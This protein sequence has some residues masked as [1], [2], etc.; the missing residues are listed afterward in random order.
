MRKLPYRAPFFRWLFPLCPTLLLIILLVQKSSIPLFFSRYS[1]R[2]LVLLIG[3]VIWVGLC[4]QIALH[5]H[6][7]HRLLSRI[8][9]IPFLGGTVVILGILFILDLTY[10]FGRA[11][12]ENLFLSLFYNILPGVCLLPMVLMALTWLLSTPQPGKAFNN[13]AVVTGIT[14]LGIILIE[15]VFRIGVLKSLVPDTEQE[16][17]KFFASKWPHHIPVEKDPNVFRILGLSDSFGQA[18][19]EKNYHYLLE[20]KLHHKYSNVEIINISMGGYGPLEQLAVLKRFGL[21]YHPDL[22]LHGVF[23]GNDFT[24]YYE[25]KTL[26][27]LM[28]ARYFPIRTLSKKGI[29]NSFRPS[30]FLLVQWLMRYMAIL[31]DYKLRQE[32]VKRNEPSGPFS[33]ESFL[34]I[35]R[36]R[37]EVCLQYNSTTGG[38][39][40]EVLG[41]I[42]EIRAKVNRV[43]AQYV[44]VIHPDQF[45][46]ED[47]LR[48]QLQQ[49]YNLNLENYDFT[50]PQ[51]FLTDYCIDKGILCLDLL[52][53]FRGIGSKGGLYF[54]RDTHYNEAGNALAANLIANFL[55]KH[56][57][58]PQID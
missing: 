46:V 32:E 43:G 26:G 28:W 18:G 23:V 35:E 33:L 1:G 19:E 36:K 20:S 2:R 5:E 49:T 50:R 51:K 39:W 56:E 38:E 30:N 11:N 29:W 55:Y 8:R 47:S 21:R 40:Q 54:I 45:Q 6:S 9:K 7:F 41:I 4:Y 57:L 25:A 3:M 42:D 17:V 15:G 22:V 37:M 44:M 13:L 48:E 53:S 12:L 10:G 52:P 31:H 58:V 14:V 34:A 16:F 27:T 24:D